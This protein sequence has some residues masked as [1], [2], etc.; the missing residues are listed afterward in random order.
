VS[1][2]TTQNFTRHTSHVTRHTSHVT[3]HTLHV[4]RHTSHVTRRRCGSHDPKELFRDVHGQGKEGCMMLLLFCFRY[5]R[6]NI[7]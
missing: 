2:D 6:C 1:R 5:N 7:L 4:T 3:R